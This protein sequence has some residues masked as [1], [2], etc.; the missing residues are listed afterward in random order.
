MFRSQAAERNSCSTDQSATSVNAAHAD[1]ENTLSPPNAESARA[2]IASVEASKKF[3][4]PLIVE[5]NLSEA[6]SSGSPTLTRCDAKSMRERPKRCC[7]G[8]ST[9]AAPWPTATM[10]RSLPHVRSAGVR[11]DLWRSLNIRSERDAECDSVPRV[12]TTP[13]AHPI[14]K[15][16]GAQVDSLIESLFSN[17]RGT[18]DSFER[19]GCSAPGGATQLVEPG[20]QGQPYFAR[21]EFHLR[22]EIPE[23][24]APKPVRLSILALN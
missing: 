9:P 20:I 7:M 23:F 14:Q 5:I 19:D 13:G 6:C 24:P 16:G 10:M 3:R 22:I 11:A 18:P 1:T 12:P 2:Y 17:D 8:T 15:H 21:I 4:F